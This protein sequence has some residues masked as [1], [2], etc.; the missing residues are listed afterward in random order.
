MSQKDE[1]LAAI[2]S[3]EGLYHRLILLVGKSGSGKTSVM[4]VEILLEVFDFTFYGIYLI[5]LKFQ[6]R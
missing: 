4:Q 3:A 6:N 2:E 1:I 5:S